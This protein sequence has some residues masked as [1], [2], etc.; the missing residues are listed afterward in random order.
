MIYIPR[1]IPRTLMDAIA[2]RD[3]EAVLKQ[4]ES[5]AA[6][7]F[8]A[9]MF[10]ARW[11]TMNYPHSPVH[12]PRAWIV[13]AETYERRRFDE[14]AFDAYQTVVDK[15]PQFERRRELMERQMRIADRYLGGERFKWKLPWQDSVYLPLPRWTTPTRTAGL[16]NKL[17]GSAPYAPLAAEAQFKA[18][19]SLRRELSV[20]SSPA[21]KTRAIEAFQLAADRY[22][23]RERVAGADGSGP[24][25]VTSK[26]KADE[27][28]K[29]L[30]HDKD[31]KLTRQSNPDVF[32]WQGF[33]VTELADDTITK[34][35]LVAALDR[36]EEMV[37]LGRF[38]IGRVHQSQASEGIYD[39]T[40]AEKSIRSYQVFLD[41]Y[42][43]KGSDSRHAPREGFESDWY[44][45]SVAE[46][47]SSIHKMR[48]EQARGH[49]ATGDFYAK[50]RDWTAAQ[51]HYALVTQE[52]SKDVVQSLTPQR[53]ALFDAANAKFGGMYAARITDGFSQYRAA[54][55]AESA[56]RYS[57][58][59][60]LYRRS[61]VNLGFPEAEIRRYAISAPVAEQVLA[62]NSRLRE[63]IHRIE[64]VQERARSTP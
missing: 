1:G 54:G 46:A 2:T 45:K 34:A 51:K 55:G 24:R 21:D 38:Q 63:D 20:F 29:V 17:V 22:G 26:E 47:E 58:A 62:I 12:G 50:T 15:W 27:V 49:L 19:E 35:E 52:M 16:Y 8:T 64:E 7:D 40:A 14:L 37:A 23:R 56:G 41:H 10:G 30:D 13:I 36:L 9:A 43:V 5:L 33:Q 42:A 60:D 59:L 28:F 53:K 44:K 4:A 61:Q 11:V 25:L 6:T 48:L 57:Q 31:G 39:Q 32:E 18:G 3:P